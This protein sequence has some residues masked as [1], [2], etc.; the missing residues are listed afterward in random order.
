M[1]RRKSFFKLLTETEINQKGMVLNE[2]A[3]FAWLA[4]NNNTVLEFED[5]N[6][7]SKF[8]LER[9]AFY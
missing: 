1:G 6:N 7:T 5:N 9:H 8:L 2:S 3:C 4:N